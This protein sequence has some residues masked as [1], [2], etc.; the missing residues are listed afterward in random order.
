MVTLRCTQKLLRR[1]AVPKSIEAVPSTTVLGDWY[2]NLVIC[3]PQQLVICMNARTLSVVLVPARESKTLGLRFATAVENYLHQLDIDAAAI[4]SELRAMTQVN[5][6]PT[7]SRS[8]LGCMRDAE[9]ALSCHRGSNDDAS[10][11]ELAMYF[12][13]SLY[14]TID[15]RYPRDL[16]HELFDASNVAPVSK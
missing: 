7:A 2:A 1:L 12:S 10:L 6:A 5:F 16:V 4:A 14:S 15:H 9:H 3:R 13:T 11:S 8:I